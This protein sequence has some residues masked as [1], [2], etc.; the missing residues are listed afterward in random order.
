MQPKSWIR[1]FEKTYLSFLAASVHEKEAKNGLEAD[2]K[3]QTKKRS[4]LVNTRHPHNKPEENRIDAR[5]KAHRIG[6]LLGLAREGGIQT[7]LDGGL[8]G[9]SPN[10]Q[11]AAC[12]LATDTC[13]R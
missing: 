5:C 2:Q 1:K 10:T 12:H 13:R 11:S 3:V 7:I 6:G 9:E 8:C 4:V